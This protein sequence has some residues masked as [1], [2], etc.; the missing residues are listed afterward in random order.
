M[1]RLTL[2]L[3]EQLKALAQARAAHAGFNDVGQFLAQLIVGEAAGAPEGLVIHS[4]R[5]LKSLLAS[6]I[7][8]PFVEVRPKDF[9]QMRKK[10][11]ER[12]KK[13]KARA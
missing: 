4:N 9:Q 11:R 5:Q 12:L 1:A 10:L 6:R 3:P 13:S 7:D 2:Q 8:G